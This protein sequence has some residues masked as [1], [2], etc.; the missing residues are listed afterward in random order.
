MKA[1]MRAANLFAILAAS[2][3]LVSCNKSNDT[4]QPPIPVNTGA[5][6]PPVADA[7]AP[8][9]T[10]P[11]ANPPPVVPPKATTPTPAPAGQVDAGTTPVD[12]G[13][14]TDAG[15]TGTGTPSDKLAAC[16]Q[17]CQGVLAS[18]AT[19]T[20][21]TDGGFPQPKDPKACQAAFDACVA[22]CKL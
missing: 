20:F 9:Q 14:S 10:P 12:A 2:S 19:P 6:T 1:A 8:P 7:A 18:C 17:K 15:A 13:T 4:E 3:C 16:A 11:A 5:P 22:A 21:P